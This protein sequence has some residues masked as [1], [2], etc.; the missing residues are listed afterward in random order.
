MLALLGN[1]AQLMDFVRQGV[2]MD[3]R[4]FREGVNT[5]V[6]HPLVNLVVDAET[7]YGTAQRLLAR[8]HE[9]YWDVRETQLDALDDAV[10]LF[11]RLHGGLR[12]LFATCAAT[13]YV[14]QLVTVPV[15][16]DDPPRFRKPAYDDS[17][18]LSTTL[19]IAS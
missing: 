1:A 9:Q 10:Q 8:A 5:C 12:P 16:D 18:V 2:A 3:S 15:L 7:L 19:L 13:K 4:T 17:K 11:E 14:A 6:C